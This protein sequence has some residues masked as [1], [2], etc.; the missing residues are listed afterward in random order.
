VALYDTPGDRQPETG[1]IEK[2]K[3]SALRIPELRAVW[4]P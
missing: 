2:F 4:L 1:R 3:L